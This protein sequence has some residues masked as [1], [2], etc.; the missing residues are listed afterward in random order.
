GE[1][2]NPTP[3]PR[4]CAVALAAGRRCLGSARPGNAGA[5]DLLARPSLPV[6]SQWSSLAC[7]VRSLSPLLAADDGSDDAAIQYAHGPNGSVCRSQT[8]TSHKSPTGVPVGLRSDLDGLCGRCLSR[9]HAG[10]SPG[11]SVAVAG[12]SFLAYWRGDILH[13]RSV[14]VH[15]P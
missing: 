9:R 3:A 1:R 15:P 13:R 7:S 12:S 11:S 14:S 8:G 10:A 5:S 2:A 6:A 4:N